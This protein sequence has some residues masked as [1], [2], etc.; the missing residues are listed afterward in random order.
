MQISKQTLWLLSLLLKLSESLKQS[1]SE[2][3]VNNDLSFLLPV[4]N[5]NYGCWCNLNQDWAVSSSGKAQDELDSICKRLLRGYKCVKSDAKRLNE[6]FCDPASI[7]YHGMDVF[8]NTTEHSV[9]ILEKSVSKFKKL[10]R[11]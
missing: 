4:L 6:N 11:S 9:D 1:I 7:V 5:E 10:Q 2:N 8:E 3:L